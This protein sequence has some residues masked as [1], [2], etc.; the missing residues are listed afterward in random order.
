METT[1]WIRYVLQNHVMI[2]A[3][4][5]AGARDGATKINVTRSLKILKVYIDAEI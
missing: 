4:G 5:T 1:E 2:L 3:G